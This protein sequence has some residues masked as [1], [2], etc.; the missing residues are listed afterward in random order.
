MARDRIK[1]QLSSHLSR[2]LVGIALLIPVILSI[3]AD[4]HIYFFML[5]L[6]VGSLTWWEFSQNLFGTQRL[7]LMALAL[8]GWFLVANGAFFYGPLGGQSIGLVLALSLGAVYCMWTLGKE[9]GPVLLNLLGRLCLGHLYIS[10]LLSFLLLLVKTSD[11]GLWLLYLLLVT[12]AADIAA[13]Y[14]G[15]KIQG[16][17]LCPKISPN[18]TVSGFIGGAVGAML[19]SAIYSAFLPSSLFTMSVLGL[20]LGMWGAGGDLFEST[21]KRALNIKNSSNLLPGHGG[22]WDRSDSLLFNVVPVYVLAD[23]VSR[24]A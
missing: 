9:T 4:D 1:Q 23:F 18:K 17:K 14:V 13:Y 3:M 24:N 2:L 11:G 8:A 22:F 19:V 20:F 7:G 21:I 5:I 15:S 6:V 16:P 10:F 12:M